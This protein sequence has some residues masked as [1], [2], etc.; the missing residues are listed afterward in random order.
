MQKISILLLLLAANQILS[1]QNIGDFTPIY[2][3]EQTEQLQIPETHSFQLLIKAGDPLTAGGTM[4]LNSDFTGYSP[5]AGSSIN[6]YVAVNSEN[7]PGGVTVLDVQYN[8]TAKLWNV[9][10]SGK[11]D[12]PAS[13]TTWANCSGTVTAWGTTVTCE[14]TD[15]AVDL[16]ADGYKDFG[17]SIEI[18]PATRQVK[19]YNNDG[20]PDKLWAM[21]RMKHENIAIAPDN[22]TVYFGN[23]TDNG[24]VY[25]FVCDNAQD[26]S[27]GTLYVMKISSG[28]S[29]IWI[30]VPN[31]TQAER[32]DVVVFSGS[33]NGTIHDRVEDVEVGPDGKIYFTV[34]S[35]GE[36]YRFDDTGDSIA[37]YELYVGSGGYYVPSPGGPRYVNFGSPDNLAFDGDGNLW[38][39]QDGS[40]SRIWI[41]RPQHTSANPQIEV[42]ANTP[43]DS[44][45]TGITFSPDYRFLFMSI[46]HPATTNL[47]NMKDAAGVTVDFNKDATLVIALNEYLVESDHG[48]NPPTTSVEDLNEKNFRI[49]PNPSKGFFTIEHEL[50]GIAPAVKTFDMTGRLVDVNIHLNAAGKITFNLHGKKKGMYLVEIA[51]AEKSYYQRIIL[52]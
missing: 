9:S 39:Q 23:E 51:D 15:I 10:S 4:P 33:V 14:E 49:Y 16:N 1:A 47:A 48:F 22:K 20:T 21:G 34:T 2:P 24:Y 19:D 7:V 38:V 8:E 52:E 30:Q 31:T 32:N 43:K 6:G 42:F 27:S 26:L 28:G 5:I 18:D 11:V 13:V 3:G 12:F 44:E 29:G 41:V 36:I 35:W 17:W 40:E 25:K 37:N 46:Q 45:P 50:T